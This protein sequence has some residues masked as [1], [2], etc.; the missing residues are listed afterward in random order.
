MKIQRRILLIAVLLVAFLSG[1]ESIEQTFLKPK[2]TVTSIKFGDVTPNWAT[3]LFDVE[4]ENPYSSKLPVRNLSF[5]LTSN[6]RPL[7]WGGA[8]QQEMLPAKS[9]KTVTLSVP[10]GYQNVIK[11]FDEFVAGVHIPYEA[12]V[13]LTLGTSTLEKMNVPLKKTGQITVPNIGKFSQ[14]EI[15]WPNVLMETVN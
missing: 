5:A 7:F 2:A 11:S 6:E 3:L 4:I 13:N 14:A 12:E 1:C 15:D 10:V 9:K 8:A